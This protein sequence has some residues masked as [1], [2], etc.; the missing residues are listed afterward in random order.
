MVLYQLII[1]DGDDPMRKRQAPQLVHVKR[2]GWLRS[3]WYRLRSWKLAR[4][5]P[6][7]H[8]PLE[9][10]H[11]PRHLNKFDL[12]IEVPE[13]LSEKVIYDLVGIYDKSSVQVVVCLPERRRRRRAVEV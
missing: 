3:L 4:S 2:L 1:S 7:H 10:Q 5:T 13:G 9:T 8:L 11:V 6:K 12:A